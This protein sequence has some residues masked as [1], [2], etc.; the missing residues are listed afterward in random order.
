MKKLLFVGHSYHNKTKSSQFIQELFQKSYEIEKFDFNPYS[1]SLQKFQQLDG[2]SY[3]VVVLWQIMPSVKMLKKYLTYDRIVYFPMYDG[4]VDVND[5]L[6]LEYAD[7]NIINFSKTLHAQLFKRGF[8][9]YYIQ[10]FP[11]PLPVNNFGDENSVFLWQRVKYIN[12]NTVLDVLGLDNI[13]KLYLHNAPDPEQIF[14]E[15]PA[16]LEDKTEITTWFDTKEDLINQ[17]QKAAIYFAPRYL[18]GIG[19]SFLEAMAMGRCVIAPNN[20]T[21]NEYITNGETGYLY[22][23]GDTKKITLADIKKIQDNTIKYIEKG[24]KNWE[25]N[26]YSILDWVQRKPNPNRV[27]IWKCYKGKTLVRKIFSI[28]NDFSN[29]KKH[30]VL[31]FLGIKLSIRV[32]NRRVCNE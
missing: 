15:P 21:M 17:I 5:E 26:K 29:G 6:W 1:D 7:V 27:K 8:S 9:S 14:I 4:C 32:N 30:K 16:L 12:A 10:Y 31:Y 13:K 24:Y 18:E 25:E 28:R 20:P 19:M 22:E 2:K 23:I 3:D 11:K